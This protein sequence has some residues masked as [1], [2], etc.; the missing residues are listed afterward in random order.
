MFQFFFKKRKQTI[1]FFICHNHNYMDI[2]YNEKNGSKL[3]IN[4]PMKYVFLSKLHVSHQMITIVKEEYC[5]VFFFISFSFKQ[6][7]DE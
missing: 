1:V 3:S 6:T 2:I 4:F 5:C 7:L